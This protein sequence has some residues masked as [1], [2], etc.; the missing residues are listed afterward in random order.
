MNKVP[1]SLL[2]VSTIGNGGED[3]LV[4]RDNYGNIGTN[5]EIEFDEGVLYCEG[6]NF[7]ADN[8]SDMYLLHSEKNMPI[9]QGTFTAQVYGFG[10]E[11]DGFEMILNQCR[12]QRIGKLVHVKMRIQFGFSAKSGAPSSDQVRITGLPFS[13]P[14]YTC[15]T[16][17][18]ATGVNLKSSSRQLMAYVHPDG[19]IAFL[20][21]ELGAT[22]TYQL[23][24][25]TYFIK[26]GVINPTIDIGLSFTGVIN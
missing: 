19:G 22:G 12:Y 5:T 1:N 16:L 23:L 26:D 2:H 17:G 20:A 15:I 13:F 25:S 8:Y 18:F 4:V 11:R 24:S 9:E 10:T 21:E 7:Y 6:G 14:S 3:M